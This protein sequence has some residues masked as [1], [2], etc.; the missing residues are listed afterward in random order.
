LCALKKLDAAAARFYADALA[1]PNL[2]EDLRPRHRYN[3]AC[4]AARA[5]CGQGEDAAQ[6]TDKERQQWRERALD[7]LRADLA[8]WAKGVEKGPPQ[9]RPQVQR[10]LRRWQQDPDLAG[11]RDETALAKPPETEREVYRKF[12]AEVAALLERAQSKE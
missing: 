8:A 6:L 5:G 4:A 12:W 3:A 9:A 2:A 7:W 1:D 10:T 11:M